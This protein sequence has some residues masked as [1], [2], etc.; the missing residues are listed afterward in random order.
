MSNGKIS[1]APDP[2]KVEKINKVVTRKLYGKQKPLPEKP[3]LHEMMN[4]YYTGLGTFF[5]AIGNVLFIVPVLIVGI[6]EAISAGFLAGLTKATKKYGK[7][8]EI[9]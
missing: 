7:H 5:G 3:F 1:I 4:S 2:Q 8:L 9:K 6:M